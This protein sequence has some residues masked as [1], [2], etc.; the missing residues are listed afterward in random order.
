[1]GRKHSGSG[2]D[3]QRREPPLDTDKERRRLREGSTLALQRPHPSGPW[4][5]CTPRTCLGSALLEQPLLGRGF[6]SSWRLG[7]WP[8]RIPLQ[9]EVGGTPTRDAAER[10]RRDSE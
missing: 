9:E 8:G 6:N 3:D 2:G 7:G 10:T 1:M 5:H 4:V